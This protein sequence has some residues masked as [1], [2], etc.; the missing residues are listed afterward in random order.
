VNLHVVGPWSRPKLDEPDTTNDDAARFVSGPQDTPRRRWRRR[1]GR[2][3]PWRVAIADGASTSFLARQ[4]AELVAE[5]AVAGPIDEVGDR[6]EA[7]RPTWGQVLAD[8]REQRT[9]ANQP[10][11]WFEETKLSEGAAST[12]VAVEID[13][14]GRTAQVRCIG[15]AAALLIRDGKLLHAVPTTDAAHFDNHPTLVRTVQPAPAPIAAAWEL[16]RGDQ[17]IV[18]SDG[19]AAWLLARAAEGP[20]EPWLDDLRDKQRFTE[21]TDRE[22]R[23]QRMADDDVTCIVVE[24]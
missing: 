6:L 10:L 7:T 3:V 19:L 16:E 15:D 12:L 13:P 9:A 17:L 21:L 24:A 22:R 11:A 14:A 4:W 5:A 20:L 23:S 18:A 2:G 1:R 8:F